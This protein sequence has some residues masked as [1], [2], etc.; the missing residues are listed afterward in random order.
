MAGLSGKPPLR[1]GLLT[2]TPL[3]EPDH[4][5]RPTIEAFAAA[6]HLAEPVAWNTAPDLSRFDA[7]LLRAT[8]DYFAD[9][10]RFLSWLEAAARQTRVLNTLDIVRWNHHKGYL[11]ELHARSVPTIPTVLAR[12]GEAVDVEAVAA[13]RGWQQGVVVKPA[14]G[15]GS[16][17]TRRFAPEELADA[18]RFAAELGQSGDVLVQPVASGF[19][20][21]GERSLIWIDGAWTHAIRKRPRYAGEDESVVA[22]TPATAEER[23]IGER[24]IAAAPSRP[25]YAR[26]DVVRGDPNTG[27]A[28]EAILVSEL[29][30]IEPSLFFFCEGGA[31]A[32]KKLVQATERAVGSG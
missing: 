12:K 19:A 26:L 16:F 27:S 15:A 22:D 20:D 6:G 11:L 9:L 30:M 28:G 24:A 2:C 25:L 14:I 5:E 23:A 31:A 10:R 29:E 3:P 4:D 21:P 13:R 17:Q 7:C 8:W 32:A 18:Q 1:I